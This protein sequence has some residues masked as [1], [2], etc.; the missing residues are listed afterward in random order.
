MAAAAYGTSVCVRARARIRPRPCAARCA[1]NGE[2]TTVL[3]VPTG[4]GCQVG[5]YAGDAL[6]AVR[7][8]AAATKTLVTHCNAMNAATLYPPAGALENRVWYVEGYALDKFAAGQWGLAM[9]A[10]NNRVGLVLD[11]AIEPHLRTRHVQ[12]AQAFRASLGADIAEDPIV[13]ARPLNVVLGSVG[14]SSRG[15]G[16]TDTEALLEAC[17]RAVVE[18]RCDAVA[19]VARFPDDTDDDAYRRGGAVDP[20]GG[21]EAAIS[22]AVV[23]ALG[24]PCAHAPC[25][26]PWD[27]DPDVHPKAAAEELGYTFLPC[28]LS[29]LHGLAPRYVTALD[30]A[31]SPRVED[32][33]DAEGRAHAKLIACA[34]EGFDAERYAAAVASTHV[35]APAPPAPSG[36]TADD[37]PLTAAHVDA[38]GGGSQARKADGDDVSVR[39][40]LDRR[41]RP[42]REP[43]ARAWVAS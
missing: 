4:I 37:D 11:A 34:G 19:V 27:A 23:Q 18:H 29:N 10:N 1:R 21:A 5:G 26:E 20:I 38:A 12:V 8:L 3:L 31:P 14:A 35:H 15:G 24:V 22:H 36:A 9:P 43:L 33:R 40:D 2:H 41:A 6:P 16:V 7:L 28:V 32:E 25:N 30:G 42:N 39:R 17:Q 13:T